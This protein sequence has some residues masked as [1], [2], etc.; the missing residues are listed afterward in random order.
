MRL[1]F[2]AVL[3]LSLSPTATSFTLDR[4]Q[5]SKN[6]NHCDPKRHSNINQLLI[7]ERSVSFTIPAM[8]SNSEN[9]I[10]TVRQDQAVITD[11]A[12]YAIKGLSG[13]LLDS[14]KIPKGGVQ[15][16][17]DD[18]R[19]A[20]LKE[21]NSDKFDASDPEWL[22][23]ENFLCAFSAPELMASF[24]SHYEI[25]EKSND[26]GCEEIQ[27]LLTLYRRDSEGGDAS[28]KP[29][30]G[31]IDLGLDSGRDELA[32]F[33]SNESNESLVCVTKETDGKV[34]TFQFGNTRAG[35][36]NNPGGNTRTVHIVNRA[37]VRE[38]SDKTGLDI[39]PM[40]FRPNIIIDG[41]EPW[42]EFKW[43]GKTLRVVP[44]TSNSD[45]STNAPEIIVKVLSRTVR[46]EGIGIDPYDP[47]TGKLDM[48]KLISK[49]YPEHG[50]YLGV[51]ASLE[52]IGGGDNGEDNFKLMS[53]GDTIE[54]L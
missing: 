5:P 7:S 25:V 23:K 15:T 53:V 10:D 3:L 48:P 14:V 26:D 29:V 27:R 44:K 42:E 49:N 19:F 24:R 2:L 9:D 6:F 36:K 46:C 8:S 4:R 20:L 45:D 33:F 12:R 35:V 43:V 34:S 1:V 40:R 50:P 38:F 32:S 39:G 22:H 54:L 51:Y 31:P 17:P 30:L 13:D 47:S 52:V 11:L 18:R 41:L 28:A 16:F 37:T 21:T